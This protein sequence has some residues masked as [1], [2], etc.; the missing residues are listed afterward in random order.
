MITV[1]LMAHKFF[2]LK[3]ENQPTQE[4]STE[5]DLAESDSSQVS[6]TQNSETGQSYSRVLD[7]K[8]DLEESWYH[9][10]RDIPL[11]EQLDTLL[12][13]AENGNAHAKY[14]LSF[15]QRHC[16]NVPTNETDL[17]SKLSEIKQENR[18]QFLIGKYVFCEGYPRDMLS[19]KDIKQ[20]IVEAARLG[21]PGAKLEF[22]VAAFDVA[23]PDKAIKNAELIVDLKREAMQHYIDAKNMGRTGALYF[24]GM[25]YEYGELTNQDY[26]EAYAYYSALISVDS[27][28][29]V[30]NLTRIEENLTQEQ[31]LLAIQR[32]K[33]YAKCC[34]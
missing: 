2:P 3:Q 5:Q 27:N 30:K 15:V 6:I 25:A 4:I 28:Y 23:A 24:L 33:N 8:N 18:Q 13:E 31:I 12:L 19:L 22:V 26:I 7:F 29:S 14:F 34:L 11:S 16:T 21:S 32:G 20:L 10:S 1:I 17:D 9:M